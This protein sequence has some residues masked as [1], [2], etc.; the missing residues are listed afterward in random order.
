MCTEHIRH[1]SQFIPTAT[2]GQGFPFEGTD[3]WRLNN[4]S[5]VTQLVSDVL[6][7]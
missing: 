5:N 3:L 2:L 4:L 6:V 7:C 1:C